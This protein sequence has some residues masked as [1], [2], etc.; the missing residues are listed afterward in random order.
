MP[1]SPLISFG[2]CYFRLWP[3]LG[4]ASNTKGPS[5]S[6]QPSV[7]ACPSGF[8]PWAVMMPPT[9]LGPESGPQALWSKGPWPLFFVPEPSGCKV[10]PSSSTE[11]G[12]GRQTFEDFEMKRQ[13]HPEPEKMRVMPQMEAPR[14]NEFSSNGPDA[15]HAPVRTYCGML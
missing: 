5:L 12:K 13:E 4:K 11:L 7:R 3:K 8:R 9:S 14:N 1:L 2:V 6:L 15:G 10:W